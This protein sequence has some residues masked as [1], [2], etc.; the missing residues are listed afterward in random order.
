MIKIVL[1]EPEIPQNTGNIARL[2][3]GTNSELIL[4][5][6]LGFSLSDKYLKRAG[7]DYW[8]HVKLNTI[9]SF[10]NFLEIYK[11]FIANFYFLSKFGEK[12]YTEISTK[13]NDIFLI[14]GNETSGLNE[15]IHNQ[16]KEKFYR[17]PMSPNIRSQNLS[18]SVAIVLYDVLR[19]NNFNDLC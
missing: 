2:C 1:V 18:N 15:K 6:P 5:E 4:I 8:K 3:A 7:L 10:E 9:S 12:I 11:K 14:F 16:F 17:I 13:P 19:K